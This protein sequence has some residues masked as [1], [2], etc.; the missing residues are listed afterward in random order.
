VNNVSVT[1]P[2]E[3]AEKVR[4]YVDAEFK[5]VEVEKE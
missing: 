2:P 4:Q 5:P 1:M 3:F